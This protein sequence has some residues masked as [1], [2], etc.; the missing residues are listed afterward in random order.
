MDYNSR[1]Q[2]FQQ[3]IQGTVDLVF[4]PMSADLFYLTGV[5]RDMPSFGAILHPGMWIEGAWL[6][7]TGGPVLALPRMTAEFGGHSDLKADIRVVGDHD[8]PAALL[9]TILT[10]LNVPSAPVL[11]LAT[12]P[13]ARLWWGCSAFIPM[14]SS[15]PPRRC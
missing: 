15:A 1:L 10:E 12:R 14:P 2:K 4:L 7:P 6:T 13:G 5:P 8:D 9:R 3:H 11:P